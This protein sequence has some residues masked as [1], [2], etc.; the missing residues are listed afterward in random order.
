MWIYVTWAIF[1]PITILLIYL[2][3][4]QAKLVIK[5][6]KYVNYVVD[7]DQDNFEPQELIAIKPDYRIPR[8]QV[9]H[10]AFDAPN[11]RMGRKTRKYTGTTKSGIR[12]PLMNLS[13]QNRQFTDVHEYADWGITK[14]SMTNKLIRVVCQDDR[15]LKREINLIDV[16][17]IRFAE[18][19]KTI[20][21][22]SRKWAWPFRISFKNNKEATIF[23]NAFWTLLFTYTG[24]TPYIA[25]KPKKRT[26]KKK[27]GS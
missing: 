2:V 14:I 8:G 11:L 27:E 22:S 6:Y 25:D 4:K 10:F 24:A 5:T 3:Y 13:L 16:E 1:I 23:I 20:H 15:P 18:D 7:I 21:I 9:L 17:E 26:R 12:L 19:N